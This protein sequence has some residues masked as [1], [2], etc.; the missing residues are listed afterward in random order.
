MIT[1]TTVALT[2]ATARVV[3]TNP[4]VGQFTLF[5]LKLGA[6]PMNISLLVSCNPLNNGDHEYSY[7]V[8]YT[9]KPARPLAWLGQKIS[10][11]F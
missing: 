8:F 6:L 2:L 1:F 3:T 10:T 9:R 7:T 4:N 5:R 11:W